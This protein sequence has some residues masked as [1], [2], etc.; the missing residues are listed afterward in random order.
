M[1][2]SPRRKP[3]SSGLNQTANVAAAVA[4]AGKAVGVGAGKADV[5][6][7][8]VAAMAIAEANPREMVNNALKAGPKNQTRTL[9]AANPLIQAKPQSQSV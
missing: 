8:V 3:P 7:Q 9:A 4:G 6:N 2:R 1:M 5:A